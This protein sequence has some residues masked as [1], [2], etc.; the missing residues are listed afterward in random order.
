[1]TVRVFK[2][3][4]GIKRSVA[5]GTN[6]RKQKE[7]ISTSN[8]CLILPMPTRAEIQNGF[9]IG[10]AY[11]CYFANK[12]QDVQ[13]GDQIIWN[14]K[15]FNVRAVAHYDVPRVGH[16]HVQMTKETA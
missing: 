13:Q 15:T 5:L 2:H 6:G 11:D 10:T 12:D 4:C 9:T 1:M 14:A 7:T 8:R 3:Y 16:V